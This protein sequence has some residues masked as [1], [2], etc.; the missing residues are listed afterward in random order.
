MSVSHVLL[1]YFVMVWTCLIAGRT[2]ITPSTTLAVPPVADSW[3]SS[4]S[5]SGRSTPARRTDSPISS[6]TTANQIPAVPPGLPRKNAWTSGPSSSVL[7]P[8]HPAQSPISPASAR[9]ASS[10]PD[11]AV[12]SSADSYWS[13]SPS[14]SSPDTEPGCNDASEKPDVVHVQISESFE[15]E[16]LGLK[17]KEYDTEQD[18]GLAELDS[19]APGSWGAPL[20]VQA[21]PDAD[22]PATGGWDDTPQDAES[23]WQE[24]QKAPEKE[25]CKV[26]GV[27]CKKGIC[28]E[29][30]K[31]VQA[32]K[33]AKAAKER[34]EQKGKKKR[35]NGPAAKGGLGR[36][37]TPT[38]NN[39]QSNPFRGCGAPVMTNWRGAP[40][41]RAIVSSAAM[42]EREAAARSEAPSS[43]SGWGDDDASDEPDADVE[44]P[45]IDVISNDGWNVSE[46]S[47][48]PWAP[49]AAPAKQSKSKN[50]KNQKKDTPKKTMT[51]AE[52]MDAASAGE[53]DHSSSVA[54]GKKSKRQGHKSNDAKSSTNGWGNISEMHW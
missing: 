49:G 36:G 16:L 18:D 47:F 32:E 33:R 14:T 20:T 52:Q 4:P 5:V 44:N 27:I 37:G 7:A 23:Y 40:R 46:A 34:E 35:G 2:D 19:I 12:N 21:W 15:E 29:Y 6:S 24:S 11:H 53:T 26:H 42:E 22:T 51:W 31:Q 9:S 43:T 48:D 10:V 28:Q 8:N 41:A 54:S 25:L 17:I 13:T 45:T 38:G 50:A 3:D 1:A 39:A 30:A